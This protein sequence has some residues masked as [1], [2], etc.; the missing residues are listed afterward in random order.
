[1]VSWFVVGAGPDW[2]QEWRAVSDF[3]LSVSPSV[4]WVFPVDGGRDGTRFRGL[5][6]AHAARGLPIPLNR[7][8]TEE[9]EVEISRL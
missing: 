8:N 1:M 5:M 9:W 3:L 4:S 7:P 2:M 6:L